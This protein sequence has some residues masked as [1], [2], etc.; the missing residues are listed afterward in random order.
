MADYVSIPSKH[1]KDSFIKYGYSEEKLF[2]NHYGVELGMF[3][4]DI[5]IKREYDVIMVGTWGF[6]KGCDILSKALKNSE[7]TLLH[8]GRI[9]PELD[10]PNEDNFTHVDP[11]DQMYLNKYYNK[12]KLMVLPSREEG[13]SLVL[14]QAMACGLPIVCTK[15][16]GGGDLKELLTD[17][18]W[19]QVI[20]FMDE[21]ILLK[22]IRHFLCFYNELSIGNGYIGDIRDEL[23]WKTYGVKYGKFIEMVFAGR[24]EI[25]DVF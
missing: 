17:D 25:E 11:V 8:V 24:E 21:K 9:E 5:N 6:R 13:L 18:K 16:T 2:V 23:T 20:D 22:S 12:A 14:C 3:F 7:I 1:V 19:I 10:F 4:P 15:D